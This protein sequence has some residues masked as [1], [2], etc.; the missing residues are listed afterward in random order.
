MSQ[1]KLYRL[2]GKANPHLLEMLGK[3]IQISYKGCIFTVQNDVGD[4]LQ[5][6]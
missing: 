6:N 5:L 2:V 3:L 1:F 4:N